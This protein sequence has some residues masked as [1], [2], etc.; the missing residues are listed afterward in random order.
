MKRSHRWAAYCMTLLALELASPAAAEAGRPAP[1]CA[2]MDEACF[3]GLEKEYQSR[4]GIGATFRSHRRFWQPMY[5]VE[6]TVP[7]GPADLAGLEVGDGVVALNRRRLLRTPRVEAERSAEFFRLTLLELR[8]GERMVFTVTRNGHERL[9]E[10]DAGPR[11]LA[12]ARNG[13]MVFLYVVH[14]T[15]WGRAYEEYL[16]GKASR[17]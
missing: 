6:S 4:G 2:T 10:I 3:E 17:R 9:I 5:S 7:G 12:A 11:S 14:G 8:R 16:R 13:L 15:E 1:P